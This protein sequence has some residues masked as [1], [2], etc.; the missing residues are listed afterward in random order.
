ME[1]IDDDL[2]RELAFYNQVGTQASVAVWLD[3][4]L[5]LSPAVSALC[6]AQAFR[7]P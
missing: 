4:L 7:L 6:D 3:K 2:S 1:N 5:S